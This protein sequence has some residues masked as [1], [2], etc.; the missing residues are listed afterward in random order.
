M[1][2]KRYKKYKIDKNKIIIVDRQS[3][4]NK[5][6]NYL[7]EYF[8][9]NKEHTLDD[10]DM[11]Y[12]SCNDNFDEDFLKNY[13]TDRDMLFLDIYDIEVYERMYK[14]YKKYNKGMK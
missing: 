10:F 9:K 12:I 11:L 2:M 6:S 4:K 5:I 8:S 3:I 13:D 1:I 14:M 7:Q